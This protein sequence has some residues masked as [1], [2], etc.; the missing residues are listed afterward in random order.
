MFWD[1]TYDKVFKE[2]VGYNKINSIE[3]ETL[4]FYSRQVTLEDVTPL[5]GPKRKGVRPRWPVYTN[6]SWILHRSHWRFDFF[7]LKEENWTP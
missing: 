7:F 6:T 4:L 1:Y 5:V 3:E 2:V